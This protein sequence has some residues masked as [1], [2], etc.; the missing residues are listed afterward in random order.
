MKESEGLQH[1]F[2]SG[3]ELL[4]YNK[5]IE[6]SHSAS[7]PLYPRSKARNQSTVL[8][9]NNFS[10]KSRWLIF[11]VIMFMITVTPGPRETED[12]RWYPSLSVSKPGKSLSH[13]LVLIN[14][15]FILKWKSI[16]ILQSLNW[17]T[18]CLQCE[19]NISLI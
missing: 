9:S 11:F 3:C 19:I 17:A 10:R 1:T 5:I 7:F 2:F 8:Y 14:S 6:A 13:F 4:E 12:R 18:C 15:T 16:A